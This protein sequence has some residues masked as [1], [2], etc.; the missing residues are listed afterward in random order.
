MKVAVA[1][2]TLLI[3]PVYHISQAMQGGL[4]SVNYRYIEVF[5]SY[6]LKSTVELLIGSYIGYSTRDTTVGSPVRLVF[7]SRH[8]PPVFHTARLTR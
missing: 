1:K 5:V 4:S 2:N 3:T 7:S 6:P 8:A